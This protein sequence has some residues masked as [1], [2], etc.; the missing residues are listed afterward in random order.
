M[1]SVHLS[2]PRNAR[3]PFVG[4]Q[5]QLGA[6]LAAIEA[7]EFGDSALALVA[8]EPGIGKT[9]L[10]R[11]VAARVSTRGTVRVLWATCWEG[12][13]APAYWPWVQLLRPLVADRD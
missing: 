12:E 6:L 3:D 7:A 8:G 10:L 9:R 5:T 1:T 4:R 11:E 2:P 13:G